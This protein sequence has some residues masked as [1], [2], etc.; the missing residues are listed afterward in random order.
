MISIYSPG[1]EGFEK[2][3]NCTLFPTSCIAHFEINGEWTVTMIHPLDERS[4]FIE[5]DAVLKVP[6][7]YGDLLYQI[8][9]YDKSDYDVQV[10]AYPIFLRA[11]GLAPFL[12]DKRAVNCTGQDALDIILG[13]SVYQGESNI[14][15]TS[16][17]YFEQMN[18]IQAINGDTDN[19][20]INRWG[21]EIAWLNNK[22]LIN[23]RLG[24]ENQF[25][26]EFGYNLS[27][28]TESYDDSE[29]ITRIYP[30]AYN[31]YMLPD[32][33]SIDSPLINNY[34]EPRPQI[35]E[36][37]NIKLASDAS[38]NDAE[39]GVIVCDTLDDLYDE[40]RSAASKD[41]ENGCDL[42]KITYQVSLVDL[43]RLDI[44][45]EF[46]DLV[47][48]NLG[49]SGKVRHR[50]M[51]I[52]TTQRVISM[53]YDCILEKIDSMT[54]GSD[55]ASF[56]EKV[57][58]V[59]SSYE[60]VVDMKSN[61]VIAEKVQG[62]INAAKASL[63]AQKDVAH[64]QEIRAMLFEDLDPNSPTFGAMC[65]GTQGIQ[66][67]KKRNETNTDWAWG[68]AIDFESII[69]DYIITGI[70][71][72]KNGSFYLNMDTGELVMNDGTFKGDL[73][74]KQSIKIGKYLI[75]AN[76]M[77]NYGDGNEGI[78]YVGEEGSDAYILMRDSVNFPVAGQVQKR[79]SLVVG[80]ASVT[81]LKE[82]GSVNS[83]VVQ[84]TVGNTSL[85]V[86]ANGIYAGSAKGLTGTYQVTNSLT[87]TN[88]LVTGVS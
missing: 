58:S 7:P 46:K 64:K 33:E 14:T 57:G 73:D 45:K 67:S 62:I 75:L 38:E 63:K 16:T 9:K 23:D 32:H 70:L 85:K 43:S 35:V 72:D 51:K 78:I 2:N 79:V 27:G 24:Q 36:Y 47:T 34:T 41:F 59:T 44:Y 3:G 18:V 22:V 20:F 48:I 60:K 56:F 28:V 30:K 49:D 65:A 69:A 52:E 25:R 88:G 11:K 53:D 61:T 29:V 17:A 13:D 76:Q 71:S 82:S 6:T 83:E 87:A 54:L 74:T 80:Q 1:N 5:K 86:D 42:P 55:T 31:G 84:I 12:W 81:V 37:S 10:T 26:A 68:T 21:G 66:I 77:K 15:K 39:N 8:K 40:L 50:K 19:S 4:D